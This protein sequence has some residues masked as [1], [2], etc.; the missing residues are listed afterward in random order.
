MP[1]AWMTSIGPVA[2]LDA[3]AAEVVPRLVER[4]PG[5]HELPNG[6]RWVPLLG[7][8]CAMARSYADELEIGSSPE[9]PCELERRDRC[10]ARDPVP[11]L[12]QGERH[13]HR[14]DS[15]SCATGRFSL[16]QTTTRAD[17]G[18]RRSGWLLARRVAARRGIRGLRRRPARARGLRRP[19]CGHRRPADGRPRRSPR[20][21]LARRSAPD[22][23]VPP[24]SSTWRRRHSSR[25]RGTSRC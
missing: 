9:R 25:D 1:V 23:R 22:P 11:A 17:N 6:N 8:G 7:R 15:R 16:E 12:L 4:D 10:P 3:G 14:L 21:E 18:D 5:Q 20:P 19:A 13:P 24:R 2:S